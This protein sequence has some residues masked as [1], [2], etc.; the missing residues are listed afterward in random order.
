MSF[1]I[2]ER[3]MREE[4][5]R[6]TL[7]KYINKFKPLAISQ[8]LYLIAGYLA[9]LAF[10]IFIQF[11]FISL[12]CPPSI[13]M[14]LALV[15]AGISF[16]IFGIG[17]IAWCVTYITKFLEHPIGKLP[18]I[19]LNLMVLLIATVLAGT[20]VSSSTGLHFKD[21]ELTVGL[22]ALIFYI[23]VMCA[24]I[25]ITLV[26]L[27]FSLE[28]LFFINKVSRIIFPWLYLIQL[29]SKKKD[30]EFPFAVV[31][32]VIGAIMTAALAYTIY[33][34][35]RLY[36]HKMY[37]FVKLF[38]Y[39]SDFQ[40]APLYPG[41]KPDERVNFHENGIISVASLKN[42]EVVIAVRKLN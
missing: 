29:D 19:A 34:M 9:A 36:K 3:A 21:F 16:L 2:D 31:A 39:Y 28:L 23:P 18:L 15:L 24:V 14:V 4:I 8:K 30:K 26:T 13:G 5:Y 11:F 41:I 12:I 6:W 38:A 32:H 25:A 37:P 27:L 33:D 1:D 17:F 22:I 20:L 40:P 42:D 35:S 7:D 10:G